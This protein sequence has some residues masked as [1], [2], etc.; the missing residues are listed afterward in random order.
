ML[1]AKSSQNPSPLKDSSACAPTEKYMVKYGSV[2]KVFVG[3]GTQTTTVKE[4]PKKT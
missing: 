2:F 4:N 1:T 3:I